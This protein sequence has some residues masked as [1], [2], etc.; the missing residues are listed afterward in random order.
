MSAKSRFRRVKRPPILPPAPTCGARHI[1]QHAALIQL[2]AARPGE[3][4]L[5][6]GGPPVMRGI[7]TPFDSPLYGG[8][9]VQQRLL[10]Y[11]L[12]ALHGKQPDT[13]A[14]EARLLTKVRQTAAPWN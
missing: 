2:I 9:T 6:C 8:N 1:A 13:A 11:A 14:I 5:L 10:A 7:F 4:C 3:R 12:C